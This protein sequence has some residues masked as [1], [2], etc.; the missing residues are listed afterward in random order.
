MNVFKNLA[1]LNGVAK[2][3]DS[4]KIVRL[5]RERYS[6]DDELAIHRQRD[7]HPEEWAEMNAYIEE[8]KRKVKEGET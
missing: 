5:I 8:C 3:I 6:V 1:E 7:D 4:Q 2:K